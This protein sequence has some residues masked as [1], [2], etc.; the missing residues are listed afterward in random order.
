M[1]WLSSMST[2][3][4]NML[5]DPDAELPRRIATRPVRAGQIRR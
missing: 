5:S 1:G 3:H 2:E 4:P